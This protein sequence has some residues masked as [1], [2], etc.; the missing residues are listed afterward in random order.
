MHHNQSEQAM[1][2]GIQPARRRVDLVERN[3]AVLRRDQGLSG[4]SPRPATRVAERAVWRDRASRPGAMTEPRFAIGIDLGT[5]N[6]VLAW[7]DLADGTAPVRGAGDPAA[8]HPAHHPLERRC[9]RRSSTIRR[10][11]RS[12]TGNSIRS[13]RCRCD[14]ALRISSSARWPASGW[15]QPGRVIHSAKSWL[16]HAGIDREASI[17]PFGSDEIPPELK[18]SP[19]EASAAYLAYLREAWDHAFARDDAGKLALSAARRRHRAR[20]LRRRRAGPDAQGGRA[21][22]LSARACGCWKNPRRRFTPGSRQRRRRRR[23]P[24]PEAAAGAG[25]TRR[26]SWCAT[27]AAAPATS[28]CSASPRVP[29]G[30]LPEIE[31]IA[32]SDHLLLGGD[33]ID[34]ALAHVLEQQAPARGRG[35]PVAPPMAPSGAP[36]APAQG[37]ASWRRGGTARMS[38][39]VSVPG[40]GASLFAASLDATMTAAEVRQWCWRIFPAD[41]GRRT[42]AGRGRRACARS[43]CP[44]PRI[45]PVSRHLA[46]F[47]AT[48]CG[49]CGAVRRRHAA[50]PLAAGAAAGADRV[51]AGT[52][53]RAAGAGG[54]EPGHRPGRRPFRRRWPADA[55]GRIRGGY[56][57]SVYLELHRRRTAR[58]QRTGLRAA[59][60]LRGRAR[61]RARGAAFELTAQSAGALHRLHLAPPAAGRARR[62]VALDRQAFHPLPPLHTALVPGRRPFNPRKSA[63][64]EL[65]VQNRGRTHRTGRAATRPAQC[66]NAA[67]AGSSNSTCASRWRDRRCRPEGGPDNLGVARE[68]ARR[69]SRRASRCSTEKSRRSRK[70]T[71]SRRW[72]ATWSASS[73]RSAPLEPAAAARPVAGAASRHHAARPFARRMKMPGSTW[74]VSCCAPA[75]AA[76]STPG[77]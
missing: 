70:R 74:P 4:P 43:A 36:G 45:R 17:L 66:A 47:L 20:V 11:A 48:G 25:A 3:E 7:V 39:H 14:E 49:G 29:A 41:G 38:S 71:T 68:G 64:Q 60:G 8:R 9:C 51:L 35:T 58:R 21:G 62:V 31:R 13:R 77:A 34:L 42:A 40:A 27:S 33:N 67:S 57:R 1:E 44:T 10:R 28:A 53:A 59:A 54:H 75:T 55:R 18:L 26:P 56:P 30:D 46:A 73:A 63:Q 22:R 37:D 65:T 32:A 61:A 6:C 52:P 23:A 24:V 12:P 16:A 5:T 2:A 69:S 76:S 15:S 19:V 72:R 50:P